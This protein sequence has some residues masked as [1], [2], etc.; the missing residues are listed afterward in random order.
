MLL[1]STGALKNLKT[2]WFSILE[3]LP[4]IGES[5]DLTAICVTQSYQVQ[6]GLS[7]IFD[8]QPWKLMQ[9]KYL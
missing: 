4:P 8:R 3:I 9:A 2:K 7:V 5:I 6:P 1:L